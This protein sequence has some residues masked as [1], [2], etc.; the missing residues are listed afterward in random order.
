MYAA[1]Y[2]L[3]DENERIPDTDEAFN[4][5]LSKA[6]ALSNQFKRHPFIENMIK[7]VYNELGRGA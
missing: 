6:Q 1:V 2:K 3:H 4:E 7:A 5:L